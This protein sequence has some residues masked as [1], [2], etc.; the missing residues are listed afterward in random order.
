MH[1]VLRVVSVLTFELRPDWVPVPRPLLV[2]LPLSQSPAVP[3]LAVEEIEKAGRQVRL[4]HSTVTRASP[5][6]PL[7]RLAGS[8]RARGGRSRRALV[9]P[10]A[11]TEAIVDES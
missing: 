4:D 10:E 7:A 8:S 6:R 11:A 9:L 1:G 2:L 5:R 3:P